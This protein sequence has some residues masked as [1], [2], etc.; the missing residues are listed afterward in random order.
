MV[1][2]L[3]CR[4]WKAVRANDLQKAKSLQRLLIN[5]AS[6]RYVAIRQ[7][8][9]LNAGKKTAGIDGKKAL[10]FS[11]RLALVSELKGKAL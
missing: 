7:V 8:T 6:A 4:I 11:E 5:S 9:Q 1:F 3:Q 10:N 2:R